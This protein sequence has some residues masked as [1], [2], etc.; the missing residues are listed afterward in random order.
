MEPL[1]TK[2]AR[3]VRFCTANRKC[4]QTEIILVTTIRNKKLEMVELKIHG[5]LNIQTEILLTGV[6]LH[7]YLKVLSCYFSILN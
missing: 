4:T 3:I 1:L 5:I 2:Q 6:L 7:D